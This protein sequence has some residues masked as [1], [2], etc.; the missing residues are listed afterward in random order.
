MIDLEEI[1]RKVMTQSRREV[2]N[3][4]HQLCADTKAIGCYRCQIYNT[5]VEVEGVTIRAC[6]TPTVRIRATQEEMIRM[7]VKEGIEAAR[8]EMTRN[9]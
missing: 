1:V 9:V 4:L 6:N 7:A 3:P 5:T 2:K 8:E